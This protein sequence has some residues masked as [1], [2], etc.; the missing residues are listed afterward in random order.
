MRAACER[1]RRRISPAD[2]K[3]QPAGAR[4]AA[5]RDAQTVAGID[6]LAHGA[7]LTP[8][9]GMSRADP[10]QRR[11][12]VASICSSFRRRKRRPV[13]EATSALSRARTRPRRARALA[14]PTSRIQSSAPA[15]RARKTAR[16]DRRA[17]RRR[18][19]S[20]RKCADEGGEKSCRA[21]STPPLGRAARTRRARSARCACCRSRL[22]QARKPGAGAAR[23]R[24]VGSRWRRSSS[25]APGWGPA[26]AEPG[27]NAAARRAAPERG[28]IACSRN[29]RLGERA[30]VSQDRQRI[31]HQR[32]LLTGNQH[33]RTALEDRAP[34]QGYRVRKRCSTATPGPRGRNTSMPGV[35]PMG[36]RMRSASAAPAT[37]SDARK[38]G[39]TT[40]P[41]REGRRASTPERSR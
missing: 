24:A 41:T 36:R 11:S 2:H 14:S 25:A 8:L 35:D 4:R 16:S 40:V 20:A 9:K 13:S 30:H 3:R 10:P 5:A 26:A 31:D 39:K 22:R 15:L 19:R 6:A 33:Q 32:G 7:E 29:L 34:V 17:A 12:L 37:A 21:A 23:A 28:S 38:P 27:S 1:R 18:N